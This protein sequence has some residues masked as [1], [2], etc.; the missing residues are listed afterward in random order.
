MNQVRK[1]GAAMGAATLAAGLAVGGI[2]PAITQAAAGPVTVHI[3]FNDQGALADRLF[4]QIASKFTK[5]HPGIRVQFQF[6]P[7][8]EIDS[9]TILGVN[10]GHPPNLVVVYSDVGELAQKGVILPLTSLFHKSHIS[11][12]I[13]VKASWKAD[14]VNGVPYAFPAASQPGLGL[15]YNPAAMRAAGLNPKD[16]PQTWNQLYAD[17]KKAVKFGPKG[18]LERV[19]YEIRITGTPYYPILEG[20]FCGGQQEWTHTSKGWAPTPVNACNIRFLDWAKKLVDLYGGYAKYAKFIASDQAWNGS[21]DYLAQGKALFRSGGY[22]DYIGYD[23]YSPKFHYAATFLPTPNGK[24]SQQIAN[25][26]TA[27]SVAFPKGQ[28]ARALNA[29]W[30]FAVWTFDQHAYLQGPTTNGDAILSQQ[31]RWIRYDLSAL[32][33]TN[34]AKM[35]PYLKYFTLPLKVA[36]E[37]T[38]SVPIAT[39]YG[40]QMDNA[41]QGVVMGKLSARA[42]LQQVARNVKTEETISAP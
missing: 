7:E 27:W 14:L 25:P 24:L 28:S 21:L 22:W 41:V 26:V 19:G 8:N 3:L 1:L 34:R 23:Q 13:F 30:Q 33:P 4:Q 20:N 12:S 16:P 37:I 11:P 18:Q 17:S 36:T 2:V 15:W 6:V 38:P 39:Y 35:T 10:S 31:S 9:K 29:A 5:S 42:A 40:T 32:S